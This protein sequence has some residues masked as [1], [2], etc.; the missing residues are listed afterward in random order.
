M[1]RGW[2][3]KSAKQI[4]AVGYLVWWELLGC[5]RSVVPYFA[6]IGSSQL[7]GIHVKVEFSVGTNGLTPVA[8]QNFHVVNQRSDVFGVQPG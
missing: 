5:R 7:E 4:R 3:E 2:C 1:S 8:R 6:K